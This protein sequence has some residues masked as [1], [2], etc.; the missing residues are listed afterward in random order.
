MPPINKKQRGAALLTALFIM[1]LVAIVATAMSGKLQVDIY[2]TR[3]IIAHDKLYF[4]S[5]AVAFWAMG[6]LNDPKKKFTQ[7]NSQ[8]MVDKY[9]ET[10]AH[11]YPSV[12][13]TGELY[14]LQ[15]R[16]NLNNLVNKKSILGFVNFVSHTAQDVN[17]PDRMNM[18]FAINDWVSSYDLAVG[19]DQYL[20]YYLH[21][22]PPYHPN[23]QFM[24]S[25]SEL[26]L[27]KDV[28]AQT[29]LELQPYV[30]ALSEPTALNLN[31]A[32]KKT[33]MS[34]SNAID[35]SKADELIA[36]RGEKGL[37]N[38]EKVSELL[39]KLNIANDQITLESSY[40]LSVAHASGENINFTVYTLIK[41]SRD[42]KGKLSINILRQ[43]FNV[44]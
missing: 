8:G 42:K 24:A 2:R 27:I 11:I 21:Q 26:R 23:H 18:A 14:D 16:F 41:R 30:T 43:S 13:L 38:L 39:K 6:N 28:S 17:A 25:S 37:K 9:P 35:D 4:A 5:Q 3:L 15:A 31:T 20:S 44:F 19:K 12:T 34:I 7:S 33:L 29:F 1:T 22:K 36:A 32:S 10:M 40:F